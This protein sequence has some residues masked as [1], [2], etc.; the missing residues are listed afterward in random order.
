MAAMA[1]PI[2]QGLKHLLLVSDIRRLGEAAMANPIQQGLK[3]PY[4]SRAFLKWAC[5]NG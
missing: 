1:N 4:R 2:Q 5:R 3:P